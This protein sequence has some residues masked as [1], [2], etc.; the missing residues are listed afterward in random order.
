MT[1]DQ[2][3]GAKNYPFGHFGRETSP[4]EVSKLDVLQTYWFTRSCRAATRA[5]LLS[6]L[7]LRMKIRG[8]AKKRNAPRLRVRSSFKFILSQLA[9]E[10]LSSNRPFRNDF[11]HQESDTGT[12]VELMSGGELEKNYNFW[13][14]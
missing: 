11:Q 8:R 5:L 9:L 14:L 2:A 12:K 7:A 3:A 1:Y 13:L 10:S 6:T 4:G